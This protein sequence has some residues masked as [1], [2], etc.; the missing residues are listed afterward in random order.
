MK[1][2][3]GCGGVSVSALHPFLCLY[4]SGSSSHTHTQGRGVVS[5]GDEEVGY[6]GAPS[7]IR[8]QPFTSPLQQQQKQHQQRRICWFTKGTI[9]RLDCKPFEIAHPAIYIKYYGSLHT[10]MNR[11]MIFNINGFF[12]HNDFLCV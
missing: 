4:L 8:L 5:D 10:I 2:K 6:G 12:A 7:C 11:T 1:E 3:L 9:E